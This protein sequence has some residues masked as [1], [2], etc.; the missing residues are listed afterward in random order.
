MAR[1]AMANLFH[2]LPCLED[3]RTVPGDL[4]TCHMHLHVGLFLSPCLPM[5][6]HLTGT[7]GTGHM[8][9]LPASAPLPHSLLLALLLRSMPG[10]LAAYACGA[11]CPMRLRPG[12]TSS[13]S[14]SERS[15][16]FVRHMPGFIAAYACGALCPMRLLAASACGALCPMHLRPGLA[17]FL[18]L[19]R[20]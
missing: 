5:Q 11:L 4:C 8:P 15:P 19:R 16:S 14:L 3:C 10:F 9:L 1:F 6:R 2:L 12:P 18:F 17:S 13:L 20:A 7:M